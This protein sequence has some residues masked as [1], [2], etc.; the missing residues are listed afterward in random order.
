MHG[1]SHWIG[2]DVH[3]VGAYAQEGAPRR[4]EAGMVFSVEPGLYVPQEDAEAPA[5]L[6]GIGIRIEDDVVV[7]SAGC[8]NLNAAIPKEAPAVEAWVQ[9]G[10][11]TAPAQRAN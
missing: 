9:A 7:T 10:E 3:D 4:L 2:L 5:E 8:E 11:A 1:T 6:R